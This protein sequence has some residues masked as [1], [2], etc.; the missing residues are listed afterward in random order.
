[1]QLVSVTNT[2]VGFGPTLTAATDHYPAAAI[3]FLVAVE[4][5]GCTHLRGVQPVGTRLRVGIHLFNLV[6]TSCRFIA[7]GTVVGGVG[8]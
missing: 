4:L 7:T 2:T 8:S 3:S 5:L 1:M 6:A